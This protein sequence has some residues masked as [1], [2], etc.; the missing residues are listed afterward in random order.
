MKK[1]ADILKIFADK[2]LIPSAASLA[3]AILGLAF[4]PEAFGI[5][6]QVGKFLYGVLIFCL[7]F[8]LIQFG[9][10]GTNIVKN[11]RAKKIKK[12]AEKKRCEQLLKDEEKENMEN[13]WKFVDDLSLQD[14][15]Y[16]RVFLENGNTPIECM[17]GEPYY[18]LLSN[19][20]CV[21]S[22]DRPSGIHRNNTME[23]EGRQVYVPDNWDYSGIKL[24]K[25]TDD[26]YELLKYSRNKY[27]RISHFDMEEE[28]NGETENA[29][30]E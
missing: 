11:M 10:Y 16:L 19:E 3:V 15:N 25:L 6:N 5:S 4:Q 29:Y 20:K 21:V 12:I 2:H 30:A 23:Y 27:K 7:C 9:K 26:F 1:F 18:G 22:T 24:Y 14:K 28:N 13:L 17:G 8:L